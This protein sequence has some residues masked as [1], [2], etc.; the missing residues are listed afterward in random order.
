MTSAEEKIMTG[1][2]L[3]E[4]LGVSENVVGFA[5]KAS[6]I[7]EDGG[8]Q[9]IPNYATPSDFHSFFR[10]WPSFI[11]KDWEGQR[12]QERLSRYNAQ[13]RRALLVRKFGA[14]S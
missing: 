3:A 6:R 8:P 13:D 9:Q 10:R 4:A 7:L 14:K 12:W 5:R 2:E 1:A 11:A